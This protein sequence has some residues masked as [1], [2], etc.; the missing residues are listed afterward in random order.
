MAKEIKNGRLDMDLTILY[1]SVVSSDIILKDELAACEC[2]K[3]RVVHVLSGDNP[4]WTGEKGFLSA[5]VIRKYS[6]PDTTYFVCGPQV[7]YNFVRG[8][9]DKLGIPKRRIRYEVFGQ[10][11]DITKS[12]GFPAGMEG[13]T[14]RIT[15]MQGIAATEIPAL[16]TES[17]ATALERAGLKIHTACRSGACGF[18]RI[19]VLEGK[20]FV[21]PTGDGRRAADKDFN[22]VH[23]CSTYPLEDMKIKINI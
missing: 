8:E 12:E 17:I 23:A 11:R 1:G 16:A 20:Y 5:D 14:F 18:C 9:L 19:K 13:K 21:C 15:V 7:M 6:A 10:V 4:G 3:V 2:D 22:Y